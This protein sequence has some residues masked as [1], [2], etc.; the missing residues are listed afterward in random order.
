MLSSA[1]SRI[2]LTSSIITTQPSRIACTNAGVDEPDGA[3]VVG[4]GDEL[5]A[6]QV[7]VAGRAAGDLDEPVERDAVTVLYVAAAGL[8]EPVGDTSGELRLPRSGWSD[9]AQERRLGR[10]V[11]VDQRAGE[12]VDR[13]A[14][15]P[16]R[17][18]PLAVRQ[19]DRRAQRFKLQR[20]RWG[21]PGRDRPRSATRSMADRAA[22]IALMRDLLSLT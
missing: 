21:V 14:V 9:Q 13:L 17:V 15:Q 10:P 6:E 16:R 19:Q 12:L 18:D 3:G 2:V 20:H 1:T 8:P 7:L 22:S 5:V 4:G 11:G